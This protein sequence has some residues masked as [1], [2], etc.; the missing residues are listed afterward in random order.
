MTE[1]QP[2]IVLIVDD[3]QGIRDTLEAILK[4]SYRVIQAGDGETAL[5]LV[6]EREVRVVLLDIRL[7]GIDGME[8]LKQIK[9]RYDDVEVVMITAVREVETAVQAMKLGAYDYITK[10]FNYDEVVN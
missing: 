3:D 4:K 1:R 9:E 8:V 10:E 6:N 2:P 5:R 7:P